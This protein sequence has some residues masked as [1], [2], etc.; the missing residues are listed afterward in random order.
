MALQPSRIECA[1]CGQAASLSDL[2]CQKCGG[3]VVKFCGGCGFKLSVAKK[4]CDSCG[5]K[6]AV[7]DGRTPFPYKKDPP[8][9]PP[10]PAAKPPAPRQAAPPPA[11]SPEPPRAKPPLVRP[12]GRPE[13]EPRG[14]SKRSRPAAGPALV[15]LILLALGALAL[16]AWWLA[17]SLSRWT[18]RQAALRYLEALQEGREA[19]AYAMLSAPSRRSCAPERFSASLPGKGWRFE[20]LR[21]G[22]ADEEWALARF[23]VL[24]GPVPE[25][26]WLYLVRE[27]D[28]WRRAYWWHLASDIEDALSAGD[29]EKAYGY[30]R[31]AARISPRDPLVNAYLCEVSYAREDYAAA[32]QACHLSLSLAGKYPSRLGED[33]TRRLHA[34]LADVYQDRLVKAP[35]AARHYEILLSL[36]GGSREERCRARLALGDSRLAA[37]EREAALADFRAAAESCEGEEDASYA[38]WLLR[39]LAGEA[40]AE[41][42]ALARARRLADGRTLADLGPPERWEAAHA[43]GTQYRISVKDPSGGTLSARADL[44]TMDVEVNPNVP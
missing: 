11:R 30:V 28:G 13:A 18:L 33:G 16:A 20:D 3:R 35:L 22:P 23:R 17:P 41:A 4:F 43:G 42:L 12:M 31:E 29:P 25:E 36:P 8:T 38:R 9:P 44:W 14:P 5:E 19:E 24:G 6:Q 27:E 10:Q 40:G 2:V 39:A 34:L 37:G 21:I 1:S 32:E 26:D 15:A 7:D